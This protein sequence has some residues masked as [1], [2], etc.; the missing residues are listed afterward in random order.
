MI[1]SLS[2]T[3][4]PIHIPG[5]LKVSVAVSS[6]VDIVSPLKVCEKGKPAREASS[7]TGSAH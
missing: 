5:D 3:P 7:D 4:D 2:V 1:K 6:G